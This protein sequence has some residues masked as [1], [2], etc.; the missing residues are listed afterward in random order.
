MTGLAH[1]FNFI[2]MGGKLIPHFLDEKQSD[3]ERV[4]RAL[5]LRRMTALQDEFVTDKEFNKAKGER[6]NNNTNTDVPP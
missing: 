1:F 2:A 6:E 3:S 4:K 5:E